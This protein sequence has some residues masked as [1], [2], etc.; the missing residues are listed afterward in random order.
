V[1]TLAMVR[2]HGGDTECCATSYPTKG[3][4]LRLYQRE[5]DGNSQ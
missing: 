2:D 4:D 1:V 3:R 5:E